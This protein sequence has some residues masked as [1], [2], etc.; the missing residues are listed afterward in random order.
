VLE[1][2]GIDALTQPLSLL[3]LAGDASVV[4][5]PAASGR[6]AAIHGVESATQ[7]LNGRTIAITGAELAGGEEVEVVTAGAVN[8]TKAQV[9]ALEG[10]EVALRGANTW[11]HAEP[12]GF[13]F[14][15][16][17]GGVPRWVE[18][19]RPF[20]SVCLQWLHETGAVVTSPMTAFWP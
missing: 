12:K 5:R 1:V 3:E 16:A 17:M 7:A 15:R 8:T 19:S 9:E 13:Y 11:M 18:A 20:C 2:V 14:S 4:L 10:N 6:A